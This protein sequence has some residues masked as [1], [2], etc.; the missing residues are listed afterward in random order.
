MKYLM[1]FAISILFLAGFVSAIIPDDCD[2]TANMVAYW[3]MDDGVVGGPVEDV[4]GNHEG[5]N[6]PQ[7]TSGFMLDGAAYFEGE[8]MI[9]IPNAA[10]LYLKGGNGFSIE[11]WMLVYEDTNKDASLLNKGSYQ[12]EWIYTEDYYGYIKATVG[13]SV[14]TSGILEVEPLQYQV[15]LTFEPNDYNLSLYIDGEYVNST[16]L[17]SVGDSSNPLEMGEDFVGLLDEVV[18]YSE[19]LSEED[20]KFSYVVT[21]NGTYNQGENYCYPYLSSKLLLNENQGTIAHDS[22]S[23]ANHGT[24]K[25]ATWNTDGIINTL[26]SVT[27]YTI[28]TATGLFTIVNTDYVWSGLE[29]SWDYTLKNE[30]E[31]YDSMGTTITGLASFADWIAIIVVTISAG[32]VLTIILSNFGR[33][34]NTI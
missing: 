22:S 16:S 31:G 11:F 12:I 5:Q 10:D 20:I 30:K 13:S 3:P 8:Q 34:R 25:S 15:V 29:A 24:I 9:I 32:I 23:N 6:F 7:P 2:H 21:Y 4:Y 17:T 19:P 27:D 33:K 28:N 1:I 14:V 18:F 26:T